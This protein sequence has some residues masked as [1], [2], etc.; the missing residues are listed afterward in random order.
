M[1]CHTW[2]TQMSPK[3]FEDGALKATLAPMWGTFVALM[4][5]PGVR[6]PPTLGSVD[7]GSQFRL[8]PLVGSLTFFKTL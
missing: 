6:N 7:L 2:P 3:T 5:Y 8:G 1:T 4:G